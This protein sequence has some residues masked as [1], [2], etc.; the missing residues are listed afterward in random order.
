MPG[1]P[2]G[3]FFMIKKQSSSAKLYAI[4]KQRQIFYVEVLPVWI[5]MRK[6]FLSIFFF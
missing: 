1:L 4:S 2:E 3:D 6:N 5:T